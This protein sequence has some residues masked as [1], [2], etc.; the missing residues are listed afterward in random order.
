MNEGDGFAFIEVQRLGSAVNS[1]SVNYSTS[2]GSAVAGTDYGVRT[3]TLTFAPGQRSR[4]FAIPITDDS[5]AE[6]TE[7]VRLKL[8]DPIG[9]ALGPSVGQLFI[10]DNEPSQLRFNSGSYS[11]NEGAGSATI[12]VVRW[13]NNSAA[14]SVDYATGNGTALAGADYTATAGQLSFA[15]GQTRMSFTVPI[16]E[17]SAVE[18]IERAN[19]SLSNPSGAIL[20]SPNTARLVINDND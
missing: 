2:N 16:L 7:T 10:T 3:G 15:P 13:G 8:S 14:A 11:V 6:F 19:L 18:G 20:G 17:D 12:T 1:A 4:V 5:Q 9:A